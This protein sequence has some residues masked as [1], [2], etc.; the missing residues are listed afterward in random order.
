[1]GSKWD[2]QCNICRIIPRNLWVPKIVMG[3]T[4]LV[5]NESLCI[6]DW[7]E[8]KMDAKSGD[9]LEALWDRTKYDTSLE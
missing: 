7:R 9:E 2:N 1:M 8:A 6:I 3:V 5:S 4:R